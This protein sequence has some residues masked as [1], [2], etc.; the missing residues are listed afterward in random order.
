MLRSTLKELTQVNDQ[1]WRLE[2]KEEATVI[3]K[4]LELQGEQFGLALEVMQA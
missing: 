4:E 2:L 1:E 3:L